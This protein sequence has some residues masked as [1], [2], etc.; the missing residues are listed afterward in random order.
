MVLEKT[1]RGTG[2]EPAYQLASAALTAVMDFLLPVRSDCTGYPVGYRLCDPVLK[3][4]D[5]NQSTKAGDAAA[6]SSFQSSGP[7][8]D[9][10]TRLAATLTALETM[11]LTQLR[12]LWTEHF[13]TAPELRSIDLMRLM[14]SWRLQARIHGG[15]DAEIRR[16]LRRKTVNDPVSAIDLEVGTKLVRE[17]QGKPYEVHVV[18]DGF[19]WQ[20]QIF[21]SLSAVARAITGTRWNGPRFFNLRKAKK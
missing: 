4:I 2:A 1:A 13:G 21:A 3:A 7:F 20:G 8:D 9:R 12:G 10:K 16:K 17:W 14:L 6:A 19:L 5:P 11:N 18:E 15:L